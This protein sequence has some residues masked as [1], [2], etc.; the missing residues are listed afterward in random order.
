MAH[1]DKQGLEERIFRI[2]VERKITGIFDI[3][4]TGEDVRILMQ[5][6]SSFLLLDN[7]LSPVKEYKTMDRKQYEN[8]KNIALHPSL[9]E[10][11]IQT[12][13]NLHRL[14]FNEIQKEYSIEGIRQIKYSPD[15]QLLWCAEHINDTR[16]RIS[17]RDAHAFNLLATNVYDDELYRSNFMFNHLPETNRIHLNQAAGQ[18]GTMNSF[19]TYSNGTIKMDKMPQLDEA[20]IPEFRGD[21]KEFVTVFYPD[22]LAVFSYP[23]CE[24]HVM[25]ELKDPEKEESCGFHAFYLNDNQIVYYINEYLWQLFDRKEKRKTGSLII[26]GHEPKE[27]SHY[28]PRL[29]NDTDWITNVYSLRPYGKH[30]IGQY[31]D[32]RT[33]DKTIHLFILEK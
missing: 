30:I 14:S 3:L 33:E 13:H 8:I 7:N 5:D 9:E 24:K 6:R 12:E 25:Y 2:K 31:S 17:V 23:A 27:A 29:K 20:G 10:F 1:L 16:F 26:E 21:K 18:N 22:G 28:F 32:D 4:A 15:G 11:I 19:L